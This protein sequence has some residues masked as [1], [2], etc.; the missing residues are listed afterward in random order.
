MLRL[1]DWL[2][3]GPFVIKK[4][5]GSECFSLSRIVWPL[6]E[7][8]DGRNLAFG[9]PSI[10]SVESI[11]IRVELKYFSAIYAIHTPWMWLPHQMV[12]QRTPSLGHLC[13]GRWKRRFHSEDTF[14]SG[15]H[16]Q[17]C[18]KMNCGQ[19]GDIG[20]ARHRF[21]EIGHKWG[22]IAEFATELDNVRGQLLQGRAINARWIC[23]SFQLKRRQS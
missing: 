12:T 9:T 23:R 2:L 17:T 14:K 13:L 10:A 20:L 8:M 15:L 6:N 1:D 7:E 19:V 22:W 16:L 21:C 18:L 3:H 11:T 4:T 5:N